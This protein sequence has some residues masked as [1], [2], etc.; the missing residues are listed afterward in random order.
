[1]FKNM[2]LNFQRVEVFV[3]NTKV[4]FLNFGGTKVILFEILLVIWLNKTLF[5]DLGNFQGV[6]KMHI[7]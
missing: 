1:M 5:K 2:F 4:L 7:F 6:L 3:V